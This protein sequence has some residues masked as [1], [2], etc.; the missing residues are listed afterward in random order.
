MHVPIRP[1]AHHD[2]AFVE[3][4][5]NFDTKLFSFTLSAELTLHYTSL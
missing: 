3:L 5:R 4:V 2:V 1:T